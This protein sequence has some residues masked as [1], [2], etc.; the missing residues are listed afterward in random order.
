MSAKA[1]SR[2]TDP[3]SHSPPQRIKELSSQDIHDERKE[4]GTISNKD[5]VG[6]FKRARIES[7][8]PKIHYEEK[9]KMSQPKNILDT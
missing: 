2:K 4:H 8:F 6:S 1:G 9:V 3:V 5:M 7:T